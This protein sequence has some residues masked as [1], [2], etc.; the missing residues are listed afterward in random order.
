MA[1]NVEFRDKD[2][3]V[4]GWPQL[5]REVCELWGIEEDDEHWAIPPGKDR[6]QNWHEFLGHAVMLTRANKET[7]TFLPS[8]LLQGLCSY[9]CMSPKLE[10]IKNYEYELQLIFFWIR[11]GYRIIVTNRW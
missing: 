7:G 1:F 4:V 6:R 9:G 10:S 3:S 2:N 11:K 5:D 8:E